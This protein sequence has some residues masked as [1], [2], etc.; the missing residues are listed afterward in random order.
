MNIFERCHDRWADLHPFWRCLGLVLVVGGVA[1]VAGRPALET[2]RDWRDEQWLKDAGKASHDGRHAEARELSLAVLRRDGGRKESISLLLRSTEALNDPRRAEVAFALLTDMSATPE[3]RQLAWRIS[4]K[5]TPA[6]MLQAAWTGL[7]EAERTQTVFLT[8]LLDRLLADGMNTE[9]ALILAGL[10]SPLDPELDLRLMRLLVGKASDEAFGEFQRILIQRLPELPVDSGLIA[11]IDEIP[12]SALRAGLFAPLTSWRERT[13]ATDLQNEL[14]LARCQLA[15]EPE[16]ADRISSGILEKHSSGSPVEV[17]R[18]CFQVR[19]LQEADEILS[20]I[21]S[22]SNEAAYRLHGLV[23]EQGGDLDRWSEL[24]TTPPEG[25]SPTWIACERAHVSNLRKDPKGRDSAADKALQGAAEAQGD[26]ALISLARQAAARALPDLSRKAWLDAIR[27]RTGP[28]PL[29]ST[30]K[31][32]V[33]SLAADKKETE[34]LEV[35]TTYRLLEPGNPV[36]IVQHDYLACLSGRLSPESL[37]ENL[38]PIHEKLPD[39]LPVSCVL[40]LGHLL[41]GQPSEALALTNQDI[42]WL[43]VSPS[44]RAIRGLVLQATGRNEDAARLLDNFPWD[45]LLQSEKRVLEGL[46]EAGKLP[47]AGG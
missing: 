32:L 9:A 23:Y 6:W 19:R 47:P 10:K 37:I 35:L 42:D 1:G 43:A 34:L 14:R 24:L 3:D 8:P 11:L 30:L 39:A 27:R 16:N 28:L 12:Q 36:V 26:D 18:W 15:A 22:S 31:K 5:H 17:A 45:S 20:R 33:E 46:L 41:A 2:Y 29:F 44:N 4:C 38:T 40:A 13:K 21:P 25:I 7:P